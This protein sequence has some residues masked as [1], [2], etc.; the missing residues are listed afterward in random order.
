MKIGVSGASGQLG[1]V[2]VAELVRRGRGHSVVGI[3]RTP[4]TVAGA[5]EGRLGDYDRP[6]TLTS[7]YAGL[8]RLLIIPSHSTQPGLRDRHFLAAIDAARA[9][10]VKRIVLISVAAARAMDAAEMYA[11]YFA[12]EQHLMRTAAR[13]TIL[14]MNYFA[15][16]FAQIAGMSLV[17]GVLTGL[18]ES[19]VGFVSREDLGAAAA[20][21]L[22]GD[23]HSG[24][25]Y[26]ATGPTTVTGEERAAILSDVSGQ[27][28][29]FV[30]LDDAQ[31]RAGLSAAGVPGEHLDALVS[32]EKS[33][34]AG[35]FNIVT[36]DVE[37][38]AGHPPRPLRA[39]LAD[40][41]GAGGNA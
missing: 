31:L 39:V 20:G 22:L 32:I 1:R 5:V 6:D 36:G 38:L 23:G 27:P 3:S 16:S 40:H 34:V 18:G 14:R 9:A 24:A 12:A 17:G 21:V 7:A 25:I 11:A 30:I 26:N 35:S 41:F 2:V 37:L 28:C 15:E 10:G 8:D 33:F 29:R 4:E 13:W 19:R